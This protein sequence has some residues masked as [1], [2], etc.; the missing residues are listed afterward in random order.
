MPNLEKQVR[1]GVA[2]PHY[3][4]FIKI[5]LFQSTTYLK[6]PVQGA[7]LDLFHTLWMYRK[8]IL[9]QHLTQGEKFWLTLTDPL[10]REL[11][12]SNKTYAQIFNILTLELYRSKGENERIRSILDKF[13]AKDGKYAE[14]WCNHIISSLDETYLELHGHTL[15]RAW[16]NFLMMI[17]LNYPSCLESIELQKLITESCIEGLIR[18]FTQP[19]DIRILMNSA[20]LYLYLTK[21]WP[22]ENYRNHAHLVASLTKVFNHVGKYY[23][24]I[25]SAFKETMLSIAIQTVTNLRKLLLSSHGL[26][27]KFLYSIADIFDKEYHRIISEDVKSTTDKTYNEWLLLLI[28]GNKLIIKGFGA[29]HPAWFSFIK[30]LSRVMVSTGL[31]TGNPK[32]FPVAKIAMQCLI[33]YA[34]TTMY[35]DFLSMDFEAFFDSTR[36]PKI[37]MS[38]D[39]INC[40]D[41]LPW[42]FEQW[43]LT[44]TGV[45]QLMTLLL[46]YL[47]KFNLNTFFSFVSI[48]EDV[49]QNVLKL[50]SV[51]AE[52][53]ALGLTADC[54]NFIFRLLTWR[55]EWKVYQGIV[56]F[57]IINTIYE[58]INSVSFI[59]QRPMVLTFYDI[60]GLS[61]KL[62]ET[63]P[64]DRI[65]NIM[66]Q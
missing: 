27:E 14:I 35:K 29:T 10:F 65:V 31:F 59:F 21:R 51:I 12:L 3:T 46:N 1:T 64:S 47:H 16:K 52:K 34:Q 23:E 49:I 17:V 22:N 36:P 41:A 19:D 6:S 53:T 40:Q 37:F 38:I 5:F 2:N 25:N 13:F 15:L 24:H 18:H 57:N 58:T 30:F 32:L 7:V 33:N 4:D 8:D 63:I 26:V 9:V 50:P 20:D 11:K 28:F 45:I 61:L 39:A 43:W 48:H 56:Y 44:Y 54:L 55:Q 42:Y 60:T 66:D 62:I